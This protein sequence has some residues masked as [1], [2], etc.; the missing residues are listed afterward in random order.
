[1]VV[2]STLLVISVTVVVALS[3]AS[4]ED[5]EGRSKSSPKATSTGLSPVIDITG[6]VLSATLMV[7]TAVETLP[8]LSS[9]V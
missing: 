4:N 8:L 6:P 9:A 5:A 7:R 1:M 2:V 3:K